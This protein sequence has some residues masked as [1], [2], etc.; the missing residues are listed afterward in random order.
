MDIARAV[1]KDT[2]TKVIGIRPGEKMHEQMIGFEDAPF[3]FEYKK[4]F[5]ILP[6]I[7]EWFSSK[8]RIKD[9]VLVN[10]DFTYSSDNNSEC[11]TVKKLE[12]WIDS[13][14]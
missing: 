6:M 9:G 1:S 3:T 12:E 10:K 14:Y 11:M 5:K 2:P 7:N 13:N 8:D 4:H